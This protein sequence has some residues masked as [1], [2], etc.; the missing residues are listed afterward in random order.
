MSRKISVVIKTPTDQPRS[1]WG[2]IDQ[3]GDNCAEFVPWLHDEESPRIMRINFER[4]GS[5]NS[6]IAYESEDGYY[7]VV[8]VSNPLS[9]SN[10]ARV[11]YG[12]N[13]K[14]ASDVRSAMTS[15]GETDS[16]VDGLVTCYYKRYDGQLKYEIKRVYISNTK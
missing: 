13:Y 7:L 3:D 9:G 10:Q 15:F 2:R 8:S 4:K 14:S 1:T 12:K 16:G 6:S 11:F 5:V